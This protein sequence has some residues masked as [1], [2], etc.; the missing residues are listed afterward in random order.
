VRFTRTRGLLVAGAL[1]AAS[2]T[3]GATVLTAGSASARSSQ[4]VAVA[5][6]GH[7]QVRPASFDNFGCMPSQ[8][9]LAKLSWTSWNSVAFGQGTLNVNSCVPDC[10][11]GKFI[12]Y[13][14]LTVLWRARPWPGHAGQ[15]YFSR[16][17]QIFTGKHPAHHPAAQTMTLPA[18]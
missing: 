4:V 6:S 2:V 7:G 11:K 17:T 12:K 9:F 16:L 10:A 1:M 8:E 14:V 3:A 15:R 13:P 18:T 5:C